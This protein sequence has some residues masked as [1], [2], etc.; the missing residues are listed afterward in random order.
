MT[1]RRT[2]ALTLRVAPGR[3]GIRDLRCLL[4]FAGRHLHMCALSVREESVRRRDARRRIAKQTQRRNEVVTMTNL[5]KYA[6]SRYLKLEDLLDKPPL[7]ERIGLV[8]IED[9]KYGERVVLIFE[10]SGHMLSLNKTSVG[11]LL[12]D[13]GE[14]DADWL[15]KLVEVYAGEVTTKD[16]TTDTILVCGVTDVPADTAI[17][18]KAKATKTKAAKSAD[19]DDEIPF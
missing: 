15:G 14:D 13:F 3:D 9:G 6:G 1:R 8:K 18:T 16:G 17:T 10:P 4:K 2:F 12:R 11:N 19:M 7:R 5:R